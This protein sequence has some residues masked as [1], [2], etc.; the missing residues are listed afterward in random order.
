[1]RFQLLVLIVEQEIKLWYLSVLTQANQFA[2]FSPNVKF[3]NN[4]C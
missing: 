4:E 1:M 3:N 2:F